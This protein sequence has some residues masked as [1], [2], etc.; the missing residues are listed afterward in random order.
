MGVEQ[1][2]ISR[3]VKRLEEALGVR[4]FERHPDGLRPTAMAETLQ[5]PALAA[6]Q[7]IK[8]MQD[9][10]RQAD[11]R[12]GLVRV[13]LTETM[14]ELLVVPAM[15]A[16]LVANPDVRLELLT[17]LPLVDLSRNEADIAIRN[18]RPQGSGLVSRKVAT[19]E[20]APFAHRD[21]WAKTASRS[22]ERLDWI[23]VAEPPQI[24][25]PE[26]DWYAEHVDAAP[27]ITTSTFKAQI[28]AVQR[29]LGVGLLTHAVAKSFDAL[30]YDDLGLP[31]APAFELWLV[32][33]GDLRTLPHVRA[34]IDWL[35]SL[36]DGLGDRRGR[37]RSGTTP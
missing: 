4:L 31:A 30:E 12:G 28:E 17:A 23:V 18:V 13:A 19:L 14:A 25:L 24:K 5:V 21:Y 10:A 3:R 2:T 11:T 36:C 20:F 29:G 32:V 22:P 1:S 26:Q 37:R 16:F 6:A 8:A 35:V 33:P 7:Q 9:A 34:V 27:R 15:G